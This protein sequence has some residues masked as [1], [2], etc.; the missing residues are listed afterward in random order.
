MLGIEFTLIFKLYYFPFSAFHASI[1]LCISEITSSIPTSFNF[2][3]ILS[4]Y[5]ASLTDPLYIVALNSSRTLFIAAIWLLTFSVLNLNPKAGDTTD[6]S[7]NA[8]NSF[9]LSAGSLSK[10]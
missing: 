7:I 5:S 1:W 8:S 9:H 10:V 3:F 2:L 6:A 4:K